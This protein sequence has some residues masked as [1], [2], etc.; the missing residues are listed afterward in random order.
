MDGCGR[1]LERVSGKRQFLPMC[2]T[3]GVEWLYV[4]SWLS[5]AGLRKLLLHCYGLIT[6]RAMAFTTSGAS[7]CLNL[8]NISI[9]PHIYLCTPSVTKAQWLCLP[10][11]PVVPFASSR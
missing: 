11:I 8:G 9:D 7:K 1:V 10:D 6:Y 5:A 4:V 3:E 2:F